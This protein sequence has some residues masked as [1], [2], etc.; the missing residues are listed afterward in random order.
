MLHIVLFVENH[1]V[2][3]QKKM[4]DQFLDRR[5]DKWTHYVSDIIHDSRYLAVNNKGE[6]LC[7]QGADVGEEEAQD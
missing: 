5:A 4:Y 1:Y 3:R 7:L 2:V 6:N